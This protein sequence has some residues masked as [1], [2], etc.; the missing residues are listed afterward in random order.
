MAWSTRELAELAGTTVN[1]IRHYHRVGLLAEPERRSNGYKQYKTHHLARL[2]RIRRLRELGMPL[3]RVESLGADGGDL[4]EALRMIDAELATSIERLQRARTELAVML[5]DPT[6]LDVPLGFSTVADQLSD[7]DRALITIYTRFFDQ[8]AL[9]DI[10]RMIEVEPSDI[11]RDYNDLPSDASES[12]RQTLAERMA[13][14]FAKHH[15]DYPWLSE[16]GSRTR[17][18][19]DLVG[20]TLKEVMPELYSAAQRDVL[21]RAIVIADL[22]SG[23]GATAAT[24]NLGYRS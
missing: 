6:S 13:P 3:D 4:G 11:E 20:A 18:D 9:S 22:Q 23:R 10:R 8:D 24:T 1:T 16:K 7:A 19:R 17:V 14:L 12:V 5:G 21:R 2:I 15:A